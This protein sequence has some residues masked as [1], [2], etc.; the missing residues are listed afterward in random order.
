MEFHADLEF[1][2]KEF[3]S[4]LTT[5]WLGKQNEWLSS[6][7]STNRTAALQAEAGGPDGLLVFA[8]TQTSGRGR[9]D[10]KWFSPSGVN[11][12][13]SFFLRPACQMFLFPQLAALTAIS[14]HQA[15]ATICPEAGLSLKW[16][17]DLLCSGRKISGIL[18]E[19]VT[20]PDGPGVIVGIGFN[21][22]S[23]LEDFPP[24]LQSTAISL[25]SQTGREFRRPEVLC[26]F[27]KFFEDNYA[28]WLN[29][30]SLSPFMEYWTKHDG[31]RGCPVKLQQ[32][33][34]TLTGLA[35]GIAPDGRL[36]L[37]TAEGLLLCSCGDVIHLRP[38]PAAAIHPN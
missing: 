29:N 34:A 28:V 30:A 3:D 20:T 36:R 37:Q 15:L 35:D 19:C 13:F 22:N 38:D 24:E 32:P 31:L 10:R 4:L 8:D 33:A 27:L 9:L 17:N 26:A 5:S 11:L 7:E 23:R 2:K 6:C 18:S 14:L 1:E 25:R 12:C 21:L 16:P